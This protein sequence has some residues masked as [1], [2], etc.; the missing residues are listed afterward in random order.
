MF[1]LIDNERNGK[2]K[3]IEKKRNI[4]GNK[5]LFVWLKEKLKT[6]YKKIK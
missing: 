2:K 5:I 3:K 4:K 6:K 1:G